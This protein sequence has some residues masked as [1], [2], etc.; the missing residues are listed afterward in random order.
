MLVKDIPKV[1]EDIVKKGILSYETTHSKN[2][3]L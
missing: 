1:T 2:L 3:N